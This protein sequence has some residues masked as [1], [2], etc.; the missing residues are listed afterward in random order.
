VGDDLVVQGEVGDE[1]FV[2]S[3]GEVEVRVDGAVRSLHHPGGFFGEIALLYDVP[4]TAT[5][6]AVGPVVALV[7]ECDQ[8]IAGVAAHARSTGAAQAVA[9]ERLEE[10]A[11]AAGIGAQA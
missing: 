7:I 10:N 11:R 1:F 3:E 6:T 9:R 5:V 4:R 8:F 2:V